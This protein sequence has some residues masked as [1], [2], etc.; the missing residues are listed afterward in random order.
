MWLAEETDHQRI[1]HTARAISNYYISFAREKCVSVSCCEFVLIFNKQSG[2]GGRRRRLYKC[3]AGNS[4]TMS[5]RTEN[6]NTSLL[7]Q[8]Y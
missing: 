8:R 5:S 1:I 2:G 3:E 6:S 7:K 4:A